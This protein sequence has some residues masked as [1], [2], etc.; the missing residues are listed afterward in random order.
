M[1]MRNFAKTFENQF[2]NNQKLITYS[3]KVQQKKR[4]RKKQMK[5]K[6]QELYA[7]DEKLT[8]FKQL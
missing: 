1:R 7:V 3:L 2:Q 8:N 4:F 5:Q 6:E